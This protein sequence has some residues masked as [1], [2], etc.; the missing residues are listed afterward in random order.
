MTQYILLNMRACCF[1][2]VLIILS[3]AIPAQALTEIG[4]IPQQWV[5]QWIPEVLPL[6]EIPPYADELDQAQ[7]ELQAGKYQAALNTLVRVKRN[8]PQ[9]M[10]MIRARALAGIGKTDQAIQAL[11]E[12]ATDAEKLILAGR[13]LLDAF[14]PSDALQEAEAALTLDPE[15]SQ[16]F[17][18]KGQALESLGRFDQAIDAYKW[19]LEGPQSFL[20]KWRADPTVFENPDDLTAIATAIHRWAT[21]TQAYK[22]LPELNDT[23]LNMFIYA[24]DVIDRQHIDSRIAAAEF[25]LSRGDVSKAEKYLAPVMEGK[26]L[27]HE[28]LRVVIQI[29]LSRGNQ[30]MVRQAISRMKKANPD[31]FDADLA[32]LLLLARSQQWMQAKVRSELLLKK[33]NHIPQTY[34]ISG[35]LQF[36]VGNEAKL[37]SSLKQADALNP[38]LSDAQMIAAKLLFM[39]YQNDPAEKLFLEVLKRTP[40][41]QDARHELGDLYLN[42]AR[43]SEAQAVLEQAYQTDPYNVRT[44]NYLRLLD[45]IARYRKV[46]TDHFVFYF[47]GDT[48]PIIADQIGPYLES[49][50]EELVSVFQY[51]PPAR[52]IV[53]V[54]PT[55]DTFSVRLAGVPGV[56]NFGVS[57][58]R[59]LATLAPRP[60]TRQGNFNWARVLKHELVHTFN[61]L[62][63]QHRVPR[64][65]TEGLAV[66]Q[67]NVPFRFREVPEELYRRT[68][69]DKLYSIQGFAGAFMNPQTP[70]DG[71]QAYTQGAYLSR[72]LYE[73]FGPDS[74]G[75]LLN[76]YAA[77]RNDEQAFLA[78]TGKSTE[79]IESGW[80]KWM[81][82]Q[83]RSWGYD[84]ESQGK[85]RTLIEQGEKAI[86]DKEV[87]TARQVFAQACDL[88]PYNHIIHQRLAWVYLQP[89]TQDIPQAIH[90]LK[91]LHML[92]L[93]NNA[94]A[95]QISKLY[96]SLNEIPKALEWAEQ[97]T[98]VDL[99]DADAHD[100]VAELAARLHDASKAERA[101]ITAER[102]RLLKSSPK[103]LASP[104]K[105][106]HDP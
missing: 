63:T 58:G 79:D 105:A 20:L 95:K 24:F 30:T 106:H 72:Y 8:D 2:P 47:D 96:E 92:E 87:F 42:Q 71:E 65:L 21:L 86:A 54:Y 45:E 67:E 5:D 25:A 3:T 14:R 57:F 33:Y 39:A 22:D 44:V 98:H 66:W 75:R 100:R 99:Y 37:E 82:E 61:L 69:S 11:G 17:L 34:G 29:G 18:L 35:A 1:I 32:D 89:S 102:I 59:V 13:I 78:A 27:N 81:K 85:V 68:M 55:D 7:A 93:R 51:R 70:S 52:I 53:Q 84:A 46:E 73:T 4:S 74:I 26:I 80:K 103:A 60:N 28:A 104:D 83:L 41:R 9:L 88:Q 91:F 97:A 56:E 31:S 43:E 94:F 10:D 40:W 6:V 62:Q 12:R 76:A 77:S 48:D 49:V 38:A 16:A 90:H 101:K 36:I 64:W 19:F 15:S 50:Y 23:L